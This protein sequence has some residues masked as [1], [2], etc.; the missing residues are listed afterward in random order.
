MS[1][2]ICLGSRE[3]AY[4]DD[5]CESI[6]DVLVVASLVACD[7]AG[8]V[9]EQLGEVC[10]FKKLVGCDEL[11]CL[12]STGGQLGGERSVGNGSTSECVDLLESGRVEIGESIRQWV[13]ERR[14]SSE[15]GGHDEDCRGTHFGAVCESESERESQSERVCYLVGERGQRREGREGGGIYRAAVGIHSLG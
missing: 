4:V 1:E 6:N 3:E 9:A 11:E 15:A 5:S 10:D 12:G 2:D 13:R 7:A 14:S 8:D